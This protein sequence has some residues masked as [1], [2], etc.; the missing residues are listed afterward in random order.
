M[1]EVRNFLKKICTSQEEKSLKQDGPKIEIYVQPILSNLTSTSVEESINVR[2]HSANWSP[3][4]EIYVS[5]SFFYNQIVAKRIKN[6]ASGVRSKGWGWQV[7][8]PGV[9]QYPWLHMGGLWRPRGAYFQIGFGCVMS[10]HQCQHTEG[11]C[12]FQFKFWRENS[13][14]STCQQLVTEKVSL[15]HRFVQTRVK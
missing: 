6:R 1:E 15:L 4:M 5:E 12:T 3:M 11:L 7:R 9:W 14:W 10:H 2:C 8:L 13:K